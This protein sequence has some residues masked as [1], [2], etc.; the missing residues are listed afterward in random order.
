MGIEGGKT[1]AIVLAA[2]KGRRM[3]SGIQKQY[4]LLDG[5]P[6]IYYSLKEFEQAAVSDIVLV[7]GEGEREYCRHEIVERYGMKKVMA[8]V[9][10]GRER[11]HSVYEGLKYLGSRGGYGPGDYVLIH[12]GARPFADGGIIERVMED[13]V[14]YGACVAGMPSKDTVKLADDAGFV[15]MTP[16]RS[17]VWTVQ[18]PQGFSYP[19]LRGAYDKMMSCAACQSGVTDDAMVVESMTEQRVRLTMGSY[20]NLKVTTPGDLELATAILKRRPE[21][22]QFTPYQRSLS[23]S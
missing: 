9:S 10:G 6:L 21:L 18:T 14:R 11:Y 2:G 16:E 19:L 23:L 20:D 17:K 22:L 4:M 15:R 1:A 13:A 3:N 12:D 5:K 7:T 8:V